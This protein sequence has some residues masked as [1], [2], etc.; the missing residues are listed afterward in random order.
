MAHGLPVLTAT[1]TVAR[2]QLDEQLAVGIGFF[3]LVLPTTQVFRM[4]GL[5]RRFHS[6][7]PSA[8]LLWAAGRA[9]LLS[10]GDRGSC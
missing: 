1:I 9:R 3:F 7:T 5:A 2:H 6:P 10:S 4:V 8:N